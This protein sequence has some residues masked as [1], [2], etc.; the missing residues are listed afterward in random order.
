MLNVDF[1]K[2]NN[3]DFK[4][5]S[6][7][8]FIL[9]PLLR[10]LGFDENNLVLSKKVSSKTI[11]GSNKEVKLNNFPDYTLFLDSVSYSESLRNS[12]YLRHSAPPRHSERSEESLKDISTT[13]QYDRDVSVLRPQHDVSRHSERSEEFLAHKAKGKKN[14]IPKK[15]ESKIHCV[16]DARH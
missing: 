8:E 6:V 3:E 11:I 16:I 15:S 14:K 7:R 2:L 13:P 10:K 4:E 1:T 9:L 5:D 12:E